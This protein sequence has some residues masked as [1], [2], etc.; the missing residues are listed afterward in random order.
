MSYDGGEQAPQKWKGKL[1]VKHGGPELVGWWFQEREW[2]V[3]WP[4]EGDLPEAVYGFW[5]IL[6]CC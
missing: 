4:L 5:D 2:K 3:C 1:F 6:V